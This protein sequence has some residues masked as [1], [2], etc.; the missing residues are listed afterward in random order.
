MKIIAKTESGYLIDVTKDEIATLQGIS[1]V[2]KRFKEPKAG[3]E[4]NITRVYDILAN[5]SYDNDIKELKLASK[6]LEKLGEWLANYKSKL[7]ETS[8]ELKYQPTN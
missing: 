6:Q 1:W 7:K 5:L 8:K 2:D 3:D 4:I